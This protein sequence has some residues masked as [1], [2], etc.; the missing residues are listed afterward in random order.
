VLWLGSKYKLI[1]LSIQDVPVLSASIKIV[2]TARDL[3]V[4]TDSGLAMSD[5]VTAVCR[6]AYYQLRQ[7]RMIVRS[8]SDDAK[9]M[10]VQSF[11]SCRLDYCN[12]L[13]YRISGGLLQR[14][15]SVQN[16]A[17]RL[18]TGASRRDHIT[19]VLRQIHCLPVKQR[20]DFK[21]AVLVYKSLRGLAPPYMSDD[22]QL[23]MDVGHR[24][25]GSSD[26]YTCVVPRTQSQIGD[27][28]FSVAGP[29]LWNN[30]PTEIRRRGTTFEHYRRY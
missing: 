26:V 4:V 2:D 17:A 29:Q 6:S 10:L 20:I 15:Q 21:L 9:K 14:L 19:L 3:G 12:S 16:T 13:L 5:H 25:L 7:L 24:H 28:S 18:I 23:V 30:L 22:C 8:L 11:V 1:K 27:R